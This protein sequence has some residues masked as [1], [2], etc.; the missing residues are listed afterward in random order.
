[1]AAAYFNWRGR[2]WY[3]ARQEGSHENQRIEATK[4]N[5]L[6]IISAGVT[7]NIR[8]IL[9][10][11][12]WERRNGIQDRPKTPILRCGEPNAAHNLRKA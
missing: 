3:A 2:G 6:N 4:I 10:A 1:M 9:A 7:R 12:S 8:L 5:A 11:K